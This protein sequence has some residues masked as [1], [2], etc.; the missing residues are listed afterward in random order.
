MDIELIIE[1]NDII[2]EIQQAPASET[3]G[4]GTPEEIRDALETLT[5]VDRLDASAIQNLPNSAVWGGITGTLTDQT[6][7]KSALDGKEPAKGIDDNYVTDAEKALLA[8]TSGTNTGDQ[9]LSGLAPLRPTA[10]KTNLVD[11]DEITGN[12]SAATFGQIKTTWANVKT[13]L[14]TYFDGLYQASNLVKRSFSFNDS[15]TLGVDYYAQS[16]SLTAITVRNIQT[17]EYSTDG[18]NYTP[19]TLPSGLPLVV[20]GDL[21][22]RIAYSAGKTQAFLE[23]NGTK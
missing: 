14:K 7:L 6:D 20:N 15:A 11:A 19:L 1:Q 16:T 10:T 12:N 18:T 3:G 23:I 22:W 17:L 8:V 2:I 9:D 5:G 13:F 4:A 21:Y